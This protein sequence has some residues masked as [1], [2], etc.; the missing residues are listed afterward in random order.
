[1]SPFNQNPHVIVVGAG[2]AGLPCALKLSHHK[3]LRVTLINPDARQE[4]TCDLY[5]TLRKGKTY[6]HAFLPQLKNRQIRFVEGRVFNV[7]PSEKKIEVRGLQSQVISYDALVLASGLRN[8]PPKIE[9]LEELMVEDNESL[10]KRVFQFKKNSH[11]QSLRTALSRIE[12]KEEAKHTRD[13]FIV[14]LGAGSTGLEVAGELAQLRG[15]NKRCRVVLVDEKNEILRD[16]SPFS[17]KLFTRSLRKTRIETV[18]GSPARSLTHDELHLENGQVIPWDLMVL[19]TGSKRPPSWID[20][21]DKIKFDNGL[22]VSNDFE[23][24]HYPNH[25]AIGDLARYTLES[26]QFKN[27]RLLPKR[28]QFSEQAGYYL[29]DNIFRLMGISTE[30]TKPFRPQDLGYL[31]SLG[32]HDGIGRIGSQPK[33]RFERLA[34][35]F[36]RGTTVD[37][38][39][40]AVRIKYLLNLRKNAFKFF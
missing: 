24:D 37:K 7:L 33:T 10:T 15:K 35:P 32:P 4:L 40:K 18:L 38:L 30:T 25:F 2:Y 36:I 11:A 12:W 26:T 14:V 17:R 31:I 34:M 5:R 29:A 21:F 8:I 3:N 16:F 22:P 39:K 13:I 1:M 28:A 19:C 9:G 23:L 27:P 20:S 6:A